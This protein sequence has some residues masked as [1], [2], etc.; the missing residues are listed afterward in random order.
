MSNF[1]K[2]KIRLLLNILLIPVYPLFAEGLSRIEGRVIDRRSGEAL[3]GVNVVIMGTTLGAATDNDGYF[4]INNLA[5]GMYRLEVT[6]IG[7]KTQV[8]ND[9]RVV[10]SKAVFVNLELQED[11]LE[12]DKIIINAG[13][14]A[15]SEKAQPS[16]VNLSRE[17][18][19]RFPGGF[20]DVVRT[21]STLPGVAVAVNGGRNDLLVRGGGPSENLYIVNNMEIPNI[22]HFGT[23]GSSSG[24][25]SFINLDF[26]DN[27]NFS[28]G[29][30][31]AAYGDKMSSV[32]ELKLSEG[33]SD[34][35]GG[36]VLISATQFGANLE[37]PVGK[38]GNYILSARKSY[39][40]LIFKAAGLPFV[41]I[42]YDY[43]L[44]ANYKFS[45][46][47]HLTLIGLAALDL[48]DRDMSSQENR[49]VNAGILDNSQTQIILGADFRHLTQSGYFDITANVNSN[50][51]RFSQVDDRQVEYFK[52]NADEREVALK[53][54]NFHSF[55]KNIG[56]QSGLSHK[57]ILLKNTSIFADSIYDR[58]GLKILRDGIGLPAR[59]EMD[60]VTG[61][62]A[63]FIETNW[64]V[65]RH[66]KLDTG[67][68]VDYISYINNSLY[69]AP[70]MAM[71]YKLNQR[72]DFKLS[73]G[74]YFQAPAYVWTLNPY[75]KNL[76]ALQNDMFV[77][78]LNY[79]FRAD[80]RA[81][82]EVYY[83]NYQDLPAGIIEGVN[84]YLVLTNTGTGYGGRED[85][86][87]SFGYLPYQSK[88]RG[89]S[90]GIEF[91]LQKRFSEIPFYGQFSLG[92]G[93]AE[94][95]ANNVKIYPG[96]YDQRF[97]LNIS[98]GYQYGPTWEISGKF[99]YFT[100]IPYTPVYRPSENSINPGLIQNLPDEYLAKRL[101]PG[102]HLDLRVD[103]YFN[104]ASWTLTT[105][106][107]IQNVYNY[108]LPQRPTY[109]FWND[110]I[111]DASDIALLPSIGVSAEF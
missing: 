80:T 50:A 68:R 60:V 10:S 88:G 8:F 45:D 61:K 51:Y 109:D 105:F 97:N 70:R 74:R 84:D 23:Q 46:K 96:Q 31:G 13:Y 56:L 49:V 86:F 93:Q 89:M 78:G 102:H 24:S 87:N 83:K 34:R 25:L 72:T 37:G 29:G 1:G 26:I 15:K 28:T 94:Y 30:F 77:G 54:Q 76:K 48:V 91:L 71:N 67:F 108:K 14:F 47:N 69:L 22:N 43:N 41:P 53:I 38:A 58:N 100:G 35:P 111:Q 42:Y 3:A 90:Y 81:S 5:P 19:R 9:V 36:K 104:F 52:S 92:F 20:E 106:I 57:Q 17:E 6:Y 21:V 40:D 98:G 55:S 82:I 75:N 33:R 107:D 99:R 101:K 95:T 18:I 73:F 11:L 103:R 27:V 32:L 39:L 16:S 79:L 66:L 63:A 2:I 7:Y 110:Q 12:T 59:Q 62:S 85:N 4:R 44:L 65:S 64:Q